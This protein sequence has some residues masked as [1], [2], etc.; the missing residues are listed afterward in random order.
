MF[1][2]TLAAFAEHAGAWIEWAALA[3]LL[4]HLDAELRRRVAGENRERGLE[5]QHGAAEVALVQLRHPFLHALGVSQQLL[6]LLGA[7]LVRSIAFE[8]GKDVNGGR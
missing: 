1:Y 5:G 4:R 6:D 7:C 3:C 2:S 8:I